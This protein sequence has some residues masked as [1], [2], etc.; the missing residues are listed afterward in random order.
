MWRLKIAKGVNSS[1]LYSTNGY[2]G[3]QT[4]EFDPDYG[5]P[6]LRKEVEKARQDF[7]ANRHRV[8]PNSDLLWRAQFLHEKNFKQTIAQVKVAA[9]EDITYGTAT[10]TL[11]RAA[12]FFSALQAS[13]GH[14][15]AENAG[16][17]FFLPPLV[18]ALY[19]T[20]H[21]NAVFSSE[22]RREIIRY[23]YCHQ[24]KGP[25]VVKTMRA[26][27]PENGYLIMAL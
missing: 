7:W 16:P 2:V 27:E 15:P 25:M 23:V 5:T 22:H 24:D 19:I 20:G 17:L 21:I 1:Y 3:R 14:L 9:G 11:R 18:M 10:T 12:H 8:K 26:L 6:E 4:W 13:D